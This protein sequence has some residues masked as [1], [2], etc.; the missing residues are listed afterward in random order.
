MDRLIIRRIVYIS[1]IIRYIF[2]LNIVYDFKSIKC[3]FFFSKR[4]FSTAFGSEI[5]PIASDG[6][7][8]CLQTPFCDVPKR[9]QSFLVNVIYLGPHHCC[10][11]I[12]TNTLSSKSVLI[13]SSFIRSQQFKPL[14]F[15]K[16]WFK[17]CSI[18]QTHLP[19]RNVP[20]VRLV[21]VVLQLF[22]YYKHFN[23]CY[24]NKIYPFFY[25]WTFY[26]LVSFC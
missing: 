9:A 5:S 17:Y 26:I 11:F 25:I 18:F 1:L 2:Y 14:F 19:K 13:T 8:V 23:F 24:Q 7:K 10:G 12:C 3:D 16:M 6:E 20:Q 21:Y 15:V 4:F 22:S